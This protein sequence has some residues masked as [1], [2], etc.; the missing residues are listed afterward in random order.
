MGMGTKRCAL[1]ILLLVAVG[2][3]AA[4]QAG[5]RPIGDTKVWARV[6][7]PGMPEGIAVLDGVV[8]VGTHTSIRGNSGQGPSKIF[9]YDLRTAKRTG[10][11]TIEGQNQD[12]THGILQ[13][14]F[15]A[16]KDLYVLDRNPPRLLRIELSG[17]RARQS[18]YA[19]FP[20]LKPCATNPEPCSPTAADSAP[21]PDY[22]AFDRDGTAYVTDL[23]AATI[24]KVPPGGGK[25]QIWFSDP[26]FDSVFGPNGI[27]VDPRGKHLFFAMTG[28]I[29]PTEP[30]QGLIYKLP[31]T[32]KPKPEDLEVFFHY[33]EPATGPDG[34]AFGRS[35]R[36]YVALAGANQVSILSPD[37]QEVARFPAATENE[38]QEVPYDLPA[39]IAFDGQGSLLVTNQSFFAANSEHWVVFDV[40]VKDTALPLIRP[41][42]PG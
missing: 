21:F 38:Q 12:E 11:I 33:L 7:E 9:M 29:Q 26:R 42:L 39:S 5:G 3:P 27:A 14:A 34:I 31:I 13:M 41:R 37:G 35:G 32:A 6:P 40:W 17:G 1:A 20:D 8:Y 16:D 15:D 18:T 28:S 30:T 2:L 10:E 24:F 4:S 23:E 36:L 19:T 22:L 25:A